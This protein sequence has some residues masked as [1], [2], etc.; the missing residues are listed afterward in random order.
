MPSWIIRVFVLFSLVRV[1]AGAPAAEGPAADSLAKRLAEFPGAERG[2]VIPVTAQSLTSVFPNYRFY[3]L[4]FRQY[5]VAMVPPEPLQAN[6]LF[7][8]KP[9][10]AVEQIR[11]TQDLENLF[12]A[13]L[14]PVTTPGHAKKAAQ[15]WLRLVEEFHQDG[16]FQFSIP[17]HSFKVVSERDGGLQVTGKAIVTRQGGNAGEIVAS[18][19]FDQTGRLAKASEVASLKRGIRPIC[20]ATKLLDPDPIVRGMAEQALLVM[21]KTAKGYLEEQ[22]ARADPELRAAIDRIWQQILSEDR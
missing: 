6:N 14:A 7:V 5:P 2:Q 8:V 17:V 19:L 10:T 9:D 11:D 12:R 22:R 18:L 13:A 15:A 21:G 16:F 3:V 1:A 20:Q 4:R